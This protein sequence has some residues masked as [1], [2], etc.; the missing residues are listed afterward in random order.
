MNDKPDD[1]GIEKAG[2]GWVAVIP[3]IIFLALWLTWPLLAQG[4]LSITS[5]ISPVDGT[6]GTFGDAFGGLNALA[7]A[8]ALAAIWWTGR[9][10][11]EELELQRQELRAQ[12]QELTET[13]GVLAKQ[14][15]EATFFQMLAHFRRLAEPKVVINVGETIGGYITDQIQTMQRIQGQFG[16]DEEYREAAAKIYQDGIYSSNAHVFGPYL[17]MLYNTLKLI[18]SAKISAEDR[19][20]YGNIV[21]AQ[22]SEPEIN[23]IAA[24][25]LS[26]RYAKE[27]QPLL[28][29]YRLLKHMSPGVMREIA[30]K[31]YPPES[32][33]D[34]EK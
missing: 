23:L 8:L 16:S 13:R 14:T 28:V 19:N 3:V 2:N 9:M 26:D 20:F 21:R 6:L 5:K 10:Q 32:F 25:C 4:F 18:Q 1:N 15:F 34:R 7:T 22:I 12:R 27:L 33:Q 24:N 29:R 31:F 30:E 11:K 17:R